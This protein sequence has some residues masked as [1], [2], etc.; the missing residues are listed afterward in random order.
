[1]ANIPDSSLTLLKNTDLIAM[2]QDGLGIGAPVVQRKDEVYVVAKDMEIIHGPKRAVVVMNL[3]NTAQ[4]I[5]LS[6]EALG[7]KDGVKFYDCLSHAD[8]ANN[9]NGTYSV[10]IPAH[11][12]RAYFVTG[13]RMEQTRYQAEEGWCQ[14]YNE[15]GTG[16]S[17]RWTAE[18]TADLGEYVGYL[19]NSADNYLEWRNVFSEKGGTYTMSIR[20]ASGEARG[21]TVSV[22]GS[23]VKSLTG[24]NSGD[25]ST[26]WGTT[27]VTI[28]LHKGMNTVR[29][30]NSTGWM[31]NIDCMTLTAQ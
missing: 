14:N 31:P 21:M 15:I 4:T 10:T 12:S 3:S 22:N 26:Q 23:A 6:L 17:P 27:D 19:G 2:N 18:T 28:S 29:L 5:D 30:S 1:M 11:G 16:T 7:F 20:Y 9:V 13:R 8:A 25:F 24:L